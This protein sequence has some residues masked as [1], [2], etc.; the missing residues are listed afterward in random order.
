LVNETVAA[1]TPGARFNSEARAT[2]RG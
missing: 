1:A 2:V